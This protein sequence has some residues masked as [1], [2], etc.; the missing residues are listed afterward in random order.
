M[1]W[2]FTGDTLSLHDTSA[3][4]F[5]QTATLTRSMND[6]FLLLILMAYETLLQKIGSS[7]HPCPD[8]PYVLRKLWH[9]WF[10]L[11]QNV[12]LTSRFFKVFLFPEFIR[13]VNY[14]KSMFKTM[15]NIICKEVY[16]GIYTG[17]NVVC[18]NTSAYFFTKCVTRY[19]W[20]G[21]HLSKD[22]LATI[23]YDSSLRPASNQIRPTD[24]KVSFG[25]ICINKQS[26]LEKKLVTTAY[27][28]LKWRD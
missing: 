12:T 20:I 14:W 28:M 9:F 15:V 24:L 26:E 19:R 23:A 18:C 27:M 5:L 7:N 10:K 6:V 13:I 22:L 1:H 2:S 17:Y 3:L 11:L 8:S 4:N 21:E 16:T 25:L